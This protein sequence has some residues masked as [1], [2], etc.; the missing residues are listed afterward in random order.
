MSTRAHSE[1][2]GAGA[3][4]RRRD[5]QTPKVRC[6]ALLPG[7][8]PEIVLPASYPYWPYCPDHGR[9][10]RSIPLGVI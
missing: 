9:R 8:C 1:F 10:N 6:S 2:H 7:L 5:R 3:V 4:P